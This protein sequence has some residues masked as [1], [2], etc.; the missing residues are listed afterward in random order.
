MSFT[1]PSGPLPDSETMRLLEAQGKLPPG[2]RP[3]PSIRIIPEPGPSQAD[4]LREQGSFYLGLES[5]K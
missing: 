2:L 4:K 5:L 3:G 1:L